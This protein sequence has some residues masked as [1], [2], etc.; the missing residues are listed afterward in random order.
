V[1]CFGAPIFSHEGRIVGALSCSVPTMRSSKQLSQRLRRLV[2]EGGREIS[3]EL[4]YRG[5]TPEMREGRTDEDNG[6]IRLQKKN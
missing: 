5:T 6:E 3:G 1:L 2:I 4:G